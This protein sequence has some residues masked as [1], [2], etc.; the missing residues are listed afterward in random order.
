M[1]QREFRLCR[2][3]GLNLNSESLSL[4][5]SGWTWRKLWNLSEPQIPHVKQKRYI[6]HLGQILALHVR[7]LHT[8]FDHELYQDEL[9]TFYIRIKN[10]FYKHFT[11]KY[12]CYLWWIDVFDCFFYFQKNA[13]N[14]LS[15]IS[16]Y[17]FCR[18]QPSKSISSPTSK[19]LPIVW[20][21]SVT[22]LSARL[23]VIRHKWDHHKVWIK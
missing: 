6:L 21:T 1:S 10:N 5:V 19:P 22:T 15:F 2:H 14:S 11:K 23:T 8:L 9:L 13:F 17:L 3:R 16:N 20:K 4:G 18:L 12:S 7:V